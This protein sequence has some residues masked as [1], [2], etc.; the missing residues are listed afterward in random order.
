MITAREILNQQSYADKAKIMDYLKSNPSSRKIFRTDFTKPFFDDLAKRRDSKIE[1]HIVLTTWGFTGCLSLNT[2]ILF[3]KRLKDYK[4]NTKIRTFSYDYWT[5]KI[6]P[7]ESVI[8]ESGK[9]ELFQIQT[10]DGRKVQASADH[11]FFRKKGKTI[12]EVRVSDLKVG[13]KLVVF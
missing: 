11:K 10:T 2:K 13:D 6:V 3:G 1:S 12:Q 9:K 5:G 4:P 7:S 8:I